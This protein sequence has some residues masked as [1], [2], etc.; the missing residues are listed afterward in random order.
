MFTF[1][2]ANKGRYRPNALGHFLY[3]EDYKTRVFDENSHSIHKNYRIL[4]FYIKKVKVKLILLESA[5]SKSSFLEM[6]FQYFT[7]SISEKVLYKRLIL[8][9]INSKEI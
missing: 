8:I 7:Y 9:F 1:L 6:S 5:T 4:E 2:A 3:S